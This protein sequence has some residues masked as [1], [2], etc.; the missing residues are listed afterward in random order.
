MR[1]HDESG[2]MIRYIKET[3]PQLIDPLESIIYADPTLLE[4]VKNGKQAIWLGFYSLIIPLAFIDGKFDTY[5]LDYMHDI[6]FIFTSEHH[7]S[8]LTRQQLLEM[9]KASFENKRNLF[10]LKLPFVVPFLDEYDSQHGTNYGD[11]ARTMYFRFAK[12][13]VTADGKITKEEIAALDTLKELFYPTKM[14][15]E[16]RP[17]QEPKKEIVGQESVKSLDELLSELNGLIGLDHVK[18]DVQELVNFL[19]VQQLR[20]ERGMAVTP[21]SKHLVFYGNPGTGKTTVA[22]L[23]AEIYKS[24]NVIS[25]GH[26]IETDRAGLVAGYVGQTAIRVH[27]VFTKALGGVLFI[28]EAYTLT[29]D[30]NDFGAEAVDTLLKLMEDHRDDVIVI[31]AGYTDKMGDF[32]AS[33]PGLKSRFNK[34]LNFEDYTP[35]QLRS[36]F[37]KFCLNGGFVLT[38][39]AMVKALEIFKVLC[40]SKDETFGNGRLAR[41]IFENAVSNHANRI[42]H[43]TEITEAILQTIEADDIPNQVKQM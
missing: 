10:T 24:L 42:I 29:G 38:E 22:R 8:H 18:K 30:G 17:I 37:E 23:L 1:K 9:H 27:E 13:F 15:E 14:A 2:P 7:G 16:S 32:L 5:E 25:K 28:D 39:A 20:Q 40:I 43:L 35:E 6:E 12:D 26:L 33:N 34:Y 31:V 21:M 11:I 19:K 4:E 41:N 36:I 3:Y